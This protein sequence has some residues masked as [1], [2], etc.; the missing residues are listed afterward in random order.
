MSL[1][2]RTLFQ[3]GGA[4]PAASYLRAARTSRVEGAGPDYL[5]AAK[6]SARWIGSAAKQTP[7]GTFWLP[8][9]DHPD[10]TA[11]VSSR[12]GLYSGGA[13]IVLFY[14][15]LA[16]ATGDDAYL[17]QARSGADYLESHW[18]E[19][20]GA[21]PENPLRSSLSLYSGL[22]GIAF[23]LAE[24]WKATKDERYRDAALAITDAIA[25]AAKPTGPGIT[26]AGNASL[27]SGDSGV[28]LYLLY[29]AKTFG[30][31]SYRQ[32][33]ARG[34]DGVISQAQPDTRGGVRWFGVSG[35]RLGL[36]KDIYFP[37]F[38]LGTA[39]VSYA[40]ARLYEE[41]KEPRFLD[42]AKQGALHLQKIAT[43]REDS[44]LV[45]YREPDKTDLY[46]LGFCH[47]P[48]GTARLF[49]QL[50]KVTQA[51]EYL[52]WTERL[53]RGIT[54]SGIPEKLTP[55]FWYVVCQC[56][57]LA[58]VNDFFLGLWAATRKPEHLAFSKRVS[59][60]LLSRV[61]DFNGQGYRWYQA[62]TRVQPSVVTAETGYMI[63]GAGVGSSLIH[64]HL[65]QQRRYEAIVLPDNP[66]PAAVRG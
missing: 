2:R 45:F 40:L 31:D 17:A 48:T 66:F 8:E 57:G 15:Q 59:D 29:A 58:G 1:S 61:T 51:H 49:H 25:A 38:E 56:C 65:A 37:N 22:S 63:G 18:R 12:L 43:V 46:Y 23:T 53:A 28:I 50:H 55:G 41:T 52:D 3:M 16:K 11:T 36:P 64:L 21:G 32:L 27:G 14:L 20:T 26:F 4:L 30:R 47:G 7:D 60:Q 9:P 34:G 19:E 10:K 42:S 6:E 35:G 5:H 62:W 39:G 54:E 13:G 33:A 44:A 24:T